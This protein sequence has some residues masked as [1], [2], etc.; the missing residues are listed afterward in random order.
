MAVV[1]AAACLPA[2]LMTP[3][4]RPLRAPRFT[5]DILNCNALSVTA[6]TR[7]V[8]PHMLAKKKG[9]IINLSSFS[10]VMPTALLTQYSATKVSRRI[11][12]S[13]PC[14]PPLSRRQAR[15]LIGPCAV[16]PWCPVV[17]RGP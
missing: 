14:L 16:R 17:R 4:G 10:A 1:A 3:T 8:L 11:L 5:Q 15:P 12:R 7:F 9:V 13:G 6:M 2:P